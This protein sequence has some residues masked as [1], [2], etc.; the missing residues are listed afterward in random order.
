MSPAPQD[1][2][3]ES[4]YSPR[5]QITA[6]NV[7]R[8]RLALSIKVIILRHNPPPADDLMLSVAVCDL[9]HCYPGQ[10][11]PEVHKRSAQI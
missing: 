2:T 9:H 3:K 4:A 5:L 1:C 6:P 10:L 8:R 11:L 7:F